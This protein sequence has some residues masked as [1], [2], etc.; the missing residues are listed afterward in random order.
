MESVLSDVEVRILGALIEKELATPDYYPLT[1]NSLVNACN[2]KSNR[3][4]VV[5]YD[6]AMVVRHMELLR[7]RNLAFE[8]RKVDSRVPKYE[9]NLRKA[10]QLTEQ[11]LAVMGILLLR[12]P[13]TVGEIKGRTHRLYPF[14]S[15][16]EVSIT[17]ET[18]ASAEQPLVVC[19]PVQPGRKEPR[20]AQLFAGE[21]EIPSNED[22]VVSL[23]PTFEP[24]L[25]NRVTQLEEQVADLKAQLE[26]IE[27]AFDSFRQQFE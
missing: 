5:Q 20:Y 27:N 11:E 7:D 16:D 9:H 12:G 10:F 13:Q 19:L 15:L 26:A 25:Q 14:D 17:L 24:E 1:L 23:S 22:R 4:P 2:Q 8:V 21:P 6:D 18:L 3:D